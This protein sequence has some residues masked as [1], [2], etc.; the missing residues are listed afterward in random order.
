LYA[1]YEYVP[2]AENYDQ[3]SEAGLI[4]IIAESREFHATGTYYI[5]VIPHNDY[6][7]SWSYSNWEYKLSYTL[8]GGV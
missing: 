5:T 7:W 6:F 8:D 2:D 1:G 4:E 3:K